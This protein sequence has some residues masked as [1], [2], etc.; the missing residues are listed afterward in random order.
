MPLRYNQFGKE[1][2]IATPFSLKR[3][4]AFC[5]TSELEFLRSCPFMMCAVAI[6]ACLLLIELNT[7]PFQR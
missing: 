4:S 6:G 2:R 1:H 3:V 7:M 5:P